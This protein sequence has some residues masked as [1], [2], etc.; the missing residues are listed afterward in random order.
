MESFEELELSPEL[1]EALAAEGIETPTSLQA[2][3]IPVLR[4]GGSVVLLAGPG[5]GSFATYS[6]AL[7]DR[8]EAGGNH[9]RAVVISV[10][11]ERSRALALA[12]ARLALATGHRVGALGVPWAFPERADIL[13]TTLDDLEKGVRSSE[14]KI[15]Q[16]AVLVLDGASALLETESD[17]VTRVLLGME[18]DGFQFALVT[19]SITPPLR[20]FVEQHG[21]RAVFL[22]AEAA[23]FGDE[24][25]PVQRGVL[26]IRTVDGEKEDALPELLLEIFGAGS[27]HTL[28]FAHS[29]DRAA[30]AADFLALHG[31]ISGAPGDPEVPVWLGVEPLEARAALK[32]SGE[33]GATVTTVSIDPPLDA[34]ELDRRHGGAASGAGGIVLA[35][36]RELPHLRRIARTAGYTLEMLAPSAP[37]ILDEASRFVAEIE[38][39]IAGEDL[40][41]HLVLLEPLLRSAGAAQVAAA[42]SFLIRK[43]AHAIHSAHPDREVRSE[44][45]SRP[46][47][48][49]RLFLSVGEK[50][51][52]TTRDLLGA[53]LGESGI[54]GEQVGKIDLRETFTKVEVQE[55]VADKVIRALNGTSI[56]GRSVRADFDRGDS[57]RSAPSSGFRGPRPDGGRGKDGPQRGTGRPRPDG[58]E[59]APYTGAGRPTTGDSGRGGPPSRGDGRS[60]PSGRGKDGPARGTGRPRPE[61][62][63]KDSAPY[64]G[65]GRASSGSGGKGGAPY[66][67][68]GRPS[69]GGGAK[70]G[71]PFRKGKP[72]AGGKP[73]RSDSPKPR[74]PS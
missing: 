32:A 18:R 53:I 13:F 71:G 11:R 26:R 10:S 39:T 47:S 43:R 33:A 46:P 58:G 50:D 56:R 73:R 66:K 68:S 44:T 30:D 70:S 3:A 22:P 31:F 62:G 63:S 17:A 65:P 54:A 57:S 19:D 41:P 38:Q 45:V 16:A 9:P 2:N 24:G 36:P 29:E 60:A 8:I 21:K 64:K 55:P 28:L 27:A 40:L 49:A 37:P 25:A 52:I 5:A 4:R 42:L 72:E 15:D 74:R 34:D 48:W 51:G 23:S 1:V 6:C 69:A 7:L 61:G 14:V 67:G 35:H 59:R 20:S 12:L